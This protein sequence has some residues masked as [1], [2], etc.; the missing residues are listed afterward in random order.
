MGARMSNSRKNHRSAPPASGRDGLLL[1]GILLVGCGALAFLMRAT[2]PTQVKDPVPSPLPLSVSVASYGVGEK[3]L[4]NDRETRQ[5]LHS[6]LD[7]PV[8]AWCVLVGGRPAV[9]SIRDENGRI[10]PFAST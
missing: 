9:T 8:A 5:M 6:R 10:W 7:S 2:K 3:S 4:A 1:A